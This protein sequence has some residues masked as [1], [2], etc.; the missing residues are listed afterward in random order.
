MPKKTAVLAKIEKFQERARSAGKK[1]RQKAKEQAQEQ[2]D[3]L[4]AGG[5]GFGVGYAEKSGMA[6]PTVDGIDPVALYAG[7]SFVA[8]MFIKDKAV[9]EILKSTTVGL[10]SV[11]L[12]KAGRAGFDTLFK[13]EKPLPS[14][15]ATSGWGE[16]IVETGEF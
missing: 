11:A 13:Y 6:L 3:L 9:K 1:A 8:T 12:Y 14:P 5:T 16:E 2:K 4:F 10:T 15:P 7:L